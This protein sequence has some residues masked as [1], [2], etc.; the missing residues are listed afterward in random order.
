[1]KLQLPRVVRTHSTIV[2]LSLLFL[3][4]I[5]GLLLSL[6]PSVEEVIL[7]GEFSGENVRELAPENTEESSGD[8]SKDVPEESPE[9]SE[10]LEDDVDQ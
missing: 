3:V 5:S 2:G 7:Y 9:K 6:S 10:A 1:M 4:G 8:I